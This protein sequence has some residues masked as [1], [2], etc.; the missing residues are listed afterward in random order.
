MSNLT[1]AEVFNLCVEKYKVPLDKRFALL[2]RVRLAKSFASQE[3]RQAAVRTRLHSLL[4]ALYVHPS[5]DVLA[6]YFQAQPDLCREIVDLIR[7]PPPTSSP[8]TTTDTPHG[9]KLLALDILVA[10]VSPRPDGGQGIPS[11]VRHVVME[12]LGVEKGQVRMC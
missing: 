6:G 12:E 9:I 4:S 7:P 11:L 3:Q 1:S 5:M 8:P 10:L 2:A